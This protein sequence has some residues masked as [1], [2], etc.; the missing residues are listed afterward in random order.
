MLSVDAIK[1]LVPKP[2]RT[3]ITQE[4]VD[5]LENCAKDTGIAEE[6]KNNFITYLSVLSKGKYKMADYINAVKFISFKLL[7]Y[8]DIDAYAAT[9]PD[10]YQRLVEEGQEQIYAFSSMYAANKLVTSIYAQ[11]M[12]PTYVLNAPL[13]QEAI[14]KLAEM[15][16]KPN[17]TDFNKIRACE[18]ILQHTKQPE[19]I[20]G[21]LTIGIEQSDTIEDLREI[22]E[23]LAETYKTLLKKEGMTL[24]EIADADIIDTSY[25]V[26]E[27]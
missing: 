7:G 6:F 5:N 9:F 27:E 12:V 18:A 25:R 13:H 22:T 10:R 2:Q 19:V 8:T 11:T 17:I 21:E 15:I 3:L 4:F 23:N 24:R 16:R 26:L 14:N 1:R 20:K